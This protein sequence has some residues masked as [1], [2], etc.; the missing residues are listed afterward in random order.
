MF[1]YFDYV[2]PVFRPPSEANSLIIQATIGCSQNQCSFCGMYKTKRFRARPLDEILAELERIPQKELGLIR[3]VFIGDGDGLVYPQESLKTLLDALETML[4]NLNRV[5]AYASP[6]SLRLKSTS[7]LEELRARKLRIIYFGLES[8][9]D[10]TLEVANKGYTAESMLECCHKAQNAGMK[11]SVTA[12]LGLAGRA[13]TLEHARATAAWIN[14]LSPAYFSLLTLFRR[15]NEKF[16]TL[17]DP[18]SNGEILAEACTVVEHLN[19][20]KTILRSNHVSNILNLAGTYP[21]DRSRL[22][23]DC[24]GALEQ[25]RRHPEW[26]NSV[27]GYQEAYY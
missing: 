19:P 17:I 27:P 6:R 8:G 18:L 5:G 13:R 10:P 12:I 22:L 2:P 24:H 3:R 9:D 15:H 14:A 23:E 1:N 21:K 11:I 4:P 16:F 20:H 25:A 26:F 7:E